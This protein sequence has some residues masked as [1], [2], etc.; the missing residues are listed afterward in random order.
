MYIVTN[1]S[2]KMFFISISI[3][4]RSGV[5]SVSKLS[6]LLLAYIALALLLGGSFKIRRYTLLLRTQN[7][8]CLFR[9]K[10]KAKNNN[11]KLTK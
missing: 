9:C 5:N 7:S 11:W 10:C 3:L 4:G 6:I 8:E 2:Q 1:K